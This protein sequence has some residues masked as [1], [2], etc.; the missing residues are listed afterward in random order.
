MTAVPSRTLGT[1]GLRVS[2]LG[3]G[4]MG[5]SFAYGPADEER[6]I[7]TL[8]HALDLGI[9]LLD[10]ADVYGPETNERLLARVLRERRDEI[11]LATKCGIAYA[12]PDRAVNGRP[13]YVRRACDASLERLGTD[14]IDLWYLHRVDPEVPIEET[15]GAMAEMV[16]AGKVRH[17]GLSEAAAAT[18]RRAHAVHPLTALQMEYSLWTRDI[19]ADILPL[20]RELGIGIVPYS[21]LGRG[22]LSG[23]ITSPDDLDE[24]DWRRGNP[25]FQGENFQRNLELVE[26]VAAIA[27]GHEASAAQIALAWVLQRG[28]DLVPIPG[29]TRPERLE[30][31]IGSLDVELSNEDLQRLEAAFSPEAV[32]GDRY[33]EAM[34]QLVRN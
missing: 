5:M 17:I 16:A 33:T 8:H 21:P 24:N 13:E 29:T 14:R 19:E 30:E 12:D 28:D 7:A 9:N 25:R 31:N 34:M 1:D 4:C 23:H 32:A 3:L 18:I 20:A 6:S 11:V 27:R 2:A 10:T 22:F 15:V 26:Q